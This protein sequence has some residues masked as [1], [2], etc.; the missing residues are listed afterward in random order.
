MVSINGIPTGELDTTTILRILGRPLPSPGDGSQPQDHDK[1]RAFT[2]LDLNMP[3]I[4]AATPPVEPV[5]YNERRTRERARKIAEEDG[6]VDEDAWDRVHSKECLRQLDAVEP[7]VG[8][9][10]EFSEGLLA[11]FGRQIAGGDAA[12]DEQSASRVSVDDGTEYEMV[13]E[14]H[15]QGGDYTSQHDPAGITADVPTSERERSV[16]GETQVVYRDCKSET[17]KTD[18]RVTKFQQD[19]E[20]RV[21]RFRQDSYT[22]QIDAIKRKLMSMEATRVQ[23]EDMLKMGYARWK[24]EEPEQA[25]T[26]VLHL[27]NACIY[28]QA[29]VRIYDILRWMLSPHYVKLPLREVSRHY[30]EQAQQL[31]RLQHLEL[32]MQQSPCRV[33]HRL[34]DRDFAAVHKQHGDYGFEMNDFRNGWT[35]HLGRFSGRM[36]IIYKIASMHIRQVRLKGAHQEDAYGLSHLGFKIMRWYTIASRW[37]NRQQYNRIGTPRHIMDFHH[38]THQRY[39]AMRYRI[40]NASGCYADSDYDETCHEDGMSDD[41]QRW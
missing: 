26:M 15:E 4:S 39:L 33:N 31:Y 24:T 25:T 38:R 36:A 19:A 22:V 6:G 18:E 30:P 7:I 17:K 8:L 3:N 35:D 5:Q 1:F 20:A 23:W 34:D 21:R 41:P 12:D 37:S 27:H 11:H 40:C 29:L 16:A 2:W 9:Q 13:T 28:S 14:E 10:K 32:G